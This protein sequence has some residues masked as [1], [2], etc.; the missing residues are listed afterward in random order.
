MDEPD[1]L[2]LVYLRRIDQRQQTNEKLLLEVL[3]RITALELANARGRAFA[4]SDA[5][6]VAGLQANVDQLRG[7]VT[8]IMR[9]L[10]LV[11]QANTG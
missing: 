1:N 2:V 9:R 5:E 3:T 7:D 6:A 10:D 4:A 8:R 11:D